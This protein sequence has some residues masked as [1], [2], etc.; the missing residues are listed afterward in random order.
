M[1]KR[2]LAIILTLSC[3]LTLVGAFSVSAEK[4]VSTEIKGHNLALMDA[5]NIIYYVDFQNVPAGAETGVLVWTNPQN[6]YI[7]GAE[8][9]KLENGWK[10]LRL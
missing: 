4:P 10:R 7:Y 9:A 2:L 8:E 3:L 1:K 6:S 5:V